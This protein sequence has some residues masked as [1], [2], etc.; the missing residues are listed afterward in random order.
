M[1]GFSPYGLANCDST[2][3]TRR[4]RERARIPAKLHHVRRAGVEP[5][6]RRSREQTVARQGLLNPRGRTGRELPDDRREPLD[7]D[8]TPGR[9]LAAPPPIRRPVLQP[10]AGD[11]EAF[12]DRLA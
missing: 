10:T 3:K 12:P 5:E 7:R 4:W 2:G 6:R 1:T 9:M 8:R 11:Y